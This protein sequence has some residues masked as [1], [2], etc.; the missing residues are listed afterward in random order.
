[1]FTTV[2]V[3]PILPCT[4]YTLLQKLCL[5]YKF[6]INSCLMLLWALTH[7]K[8]RPYNFHIC[9]T[10][11]SD[12]TLVISWNDLRESQSI[13]SV[14]GHKTS[15]LYKVINNIRFY[16]Y[17]MWKS[18]KVFCFAWLQ[19][20]VFKTDFLQKDLPHLSQGKG[21]SFVW[22]REW[23]VSCELVQKDL[24]QIL[25]VKGFSFLWM[26]VWVLRWDL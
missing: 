24:E 15:D 1:M 21:F 5:S 14:I 7:G 23:F 16:K 6:I 4:L 25:H 22:M 11:R 26:R 19:E 10:H 13:C 20:W 12:I 2:K 8:C 17:Q 3:V 9:G 18:V